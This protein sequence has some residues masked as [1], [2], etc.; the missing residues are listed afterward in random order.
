MIRILTAV[1]FFLLPSCQADAAAPPGVDPESPVAKWFNSL[2]RADGV[3]CC[4]T[5][6]CRPNPVR[7]SAGEIQTMFDGRWVNVAQSKIVWREDN[8]LGVS[9]ACIEP[10][11]KTIM[12]VVPNSGI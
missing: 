4:S 5:A 2:V 12:C 11:S 9:I 6:D 7:E 3:G 10:V 1:A 8:P